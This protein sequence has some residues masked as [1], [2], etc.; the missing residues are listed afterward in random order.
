[1]KG[2][3]GLREPDVSNKLNVYLNHFFYR[4]FSFSKVRIIFIAMVH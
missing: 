4:G 1:M 2:S 3:V